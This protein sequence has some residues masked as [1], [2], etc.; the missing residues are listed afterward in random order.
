M[1]ADLRFVLLVRKHPTE[2]AE[3]HLD[4]LV[5]A[6]RGKAPGLTLVADQIGWRLLVDRTRLDHRVSRDGTIAL[7]GDGFDRSGR[8]IDASHL[9]A[10]TAK[11]WS[12]ADRGRWLIDHSWGRYVALLRPAHDS[13]AV[14]CLRD[15]TGA[16]QAYRCRE[17][18]L[19]LVASDTPKWLFDLIDHKV[20]PD[21]ATIGAT[22]AHPTVATY[23]SL[24]AGLDMVPAGTLLPLF[25]GA[26]TRLWWP[27]GF[28]V[29]RTDIGQ[30][31]AAAM[32][33]ERVTMCCASWAR[34][35]PRPLLEL[36]GGLDSAIVLAS[37]GD[38]AATAINF[39]TGF[40]AG[41]ERNHARAAAER[42]ATPL[43]ERLATPEAVDYLALVND[44]PAAAPR[45][46]GLDPQHDDVVAAEATERHA[47][48]IFTGQGGDGL[49]LQM[50]ATQ[51]AIDR[52]R[53]GLDARALQLAGVVARRARRSLWRVLAEI[54]RDRLCAHVTPPMRFLSPLMSEGLIAALSANPIAHPWLDGLERL[55]PGKRLHIEVLANGQLFMLP[56][57]RGRVVPLIHP[58]LSQPILEACLALPTFVLAPDDRDRG[59]AR[60]AFADLVP[61]GILRRHSKGEASSYFSRG[62]VANLPLVRE[63]LLDGALVQA[64]LLD[65]DALD[66]TLD[67]ER[68]LW[69]DEAGLPPLYLNIEAWV[70][71]WLD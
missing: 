62:L 68:L 40:S 63:W 33:R 56:T 28:A 66:T 30:Q 32:L 14:S 65:R 46:Y 22:L 31:D 29:P 50:P 60:D 54:G 18:D 2:Q 52:A 36:S 48:A 7:L 23:R 57:R 11:D 3:R 15:P 6:I 67:A 19:A 42:A 53:L 8:S 13:D 21:W 45:L 47:D 9:D 59:L 39:T 26:P 27:T 5:A 44:V 24:L 61:P 70:R 4:G 35:Y 43:I 25:D 12:I 10:L 1:S 16:I 51:I 37:L 49:F 55:P 20:T 71:Q 34:R 64:G 41:D 17:Q 58:L 38:A 69:A